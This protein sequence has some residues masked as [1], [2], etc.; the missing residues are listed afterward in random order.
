MA[1]QPKMSRFSNGSNRQ[2]HRIKDFG[3]NYIN[4]GRPRLYEASS[5]T[6]ALKNEIN[7]FK[8]RAI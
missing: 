6:L 8:S 7:I 5:C 4:K 2:Y 3:E 1:R